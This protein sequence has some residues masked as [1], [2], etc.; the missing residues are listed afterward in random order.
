[1][2]SKETFKF[3]CPNGMEEPAILFRLHEREVIVNPLM[4]YNI[5][6][7]CH[8][9]DYFSREIT[10][11]FQLFKDEVCGY[12]HDSLFGD[13]SINFE[14]NS[15]IESALQILDELCYTIIQGNQSF[16]KDFDKN[17]A[18]KMKAG[19]KNLII[20][21]NYSQIIENEVRVER[22]TFNFVEPYNCDTHFILSIGERTYESDLSDWTTDFNRIRLAIE[23]FIYC[24]NADINLFFE[25][26]P[27]TIRLKEQNFYSSDFRV[28]NKK[29]V[30]KVTIVPN[31]F[32][33]GPNLY[34]WCNPRQLIGSLYLGLLRICIV[35]TD[36]FENEHSGNWNE[37]RL[38]TYNKLQSCVIENYI[39]GIHEGD[40]TS[41]PR[42]RIIENV[43]SMIEDFR[44][45]EIQFHYDKE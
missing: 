42:Q 45:L 15:F 5:F 3:K 24:A 23:K 17:T 13:Y 7:D 26:S 40:Y 22:F 29:D 39:K 6:W 8:K 4:L 35:E 12:F 16:Y 11:H 41:F 44:N 43:D 30:T 10:A 31:E 9:E 32:V 20:P 28:S 18:I 33:K 21:K 1:M 27:T 19:L 25:D 36:E 38:A 14:R 34:G 2:R 37:F